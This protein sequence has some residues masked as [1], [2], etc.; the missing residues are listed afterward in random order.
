VDTDDIVGN[1]S[2]EID[3]NEGNCPNCGKP[4][5]DGPVVV[6]QALFSMTL[7]M[8][9]LGAIAGLFVIFLLAQ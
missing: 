9:G 1:D 4:V 5:L 8:A 3:W 6:S 7:V 2:R